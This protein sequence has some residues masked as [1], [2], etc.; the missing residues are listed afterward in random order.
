MPPNADAPPLPSIKELATD[1]RYMMATAGA[2]LNILGIFVPVFY[3]QLYAINHGMDQQLAFYTITILN[4]ASVIGRIVPNL[5]G[6]IWGSFNALIISTA[7]CTILSICM[8]AAKNTAGIL[9]ICVFYGLFSGAYFS[10]ISPL[11]ASLANH[12]SETGIRL[13][14]GFTVVSFSCLAGTPIAGALLTP[15]LHWARP[16]AFSGA[17]LFA[18]LLFLIGARWMTARQRGT[19]RV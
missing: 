9:A 4:G 10:L 12:V 14:V 13:G 19:W 6:D 17:T 3:M 11:F 8:L 7:A 16:I 2:F 15:H 18:G 1:A 5:I